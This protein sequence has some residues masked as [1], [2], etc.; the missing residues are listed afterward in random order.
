MEQSLLRAQ[1]ARDVTSAAVIQIAS[2]LDLLEIAR[3]DPGAHTDQT[4]GA[5]EQLQQ[6]W[7]E[8]KQVLAEAQ[9]TEPEPDEAKDENE[10][11]LNIL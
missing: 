6:R 5:S 11:L 1:Q 7:T 3:T 4:D 10:V 8:W 9:Q 2:T